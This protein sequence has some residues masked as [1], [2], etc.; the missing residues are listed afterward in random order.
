[1]GG[2]GPGYE[3]GQ[4]RRG[5]GCSHESTRGLEPVESLERDWGMSDRERR[6]R[7]LCGLLRGWLD[8][9]S[10]TGVWAGLYNLSEAGSDF[11]SCLFLPSQSL[12]TLF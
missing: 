10:S 5:S 3:G 6:A 7:A 11:L 8:C 12:F 4:S 1:M 9:L 2:G